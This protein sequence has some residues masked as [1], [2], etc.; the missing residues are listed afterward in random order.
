MKKV[1][2]D[3]YHL[4]QFNF[5]K[6]AI[7]QFDPEEVDI[8]CVNR[9]KLLPVIRHELPGYRVTCIGDYKYNK[10]MAS[11]IFRIIIPRMVR[12]WRMVSRSKYKFILTAHYQANVVARLRQIPNIAFNDDP[13]RFV[14]PVLKLSANEVYLPP[15]RQKYPG[16]KTFNALKEWAYLSPRYFTPREEALEPYGLQ[17][18]RYIF[19]REVSTETSNYLTQQEDIILS[20]SRQFPPSWPVVLSLERKE[21]AGQYPKEWIILKEPVADIHSLMYYSRIVLSSGDSMAR[22]GALLGVPAI[23]AGQ[24]D[25][26]ANQLLM[27]KGMLL[28]AEP[29]QVVPTIHAILEGSISFEEQSS[30]R[31]KLFREWDDITALILN[32]INQTSNIL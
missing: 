7:L 3:I 5:L 15:F 31:Q 19:I 13:R 21:N 23:Y 2:I 11:M 12:M 16:V 22:E 9:G 20:I 8:F 29:A 27:E 24:R 14:F 32:K 1:L 30:F 4:P 28:K 6:N 26:P 18:K 10:G 25:M 17:P